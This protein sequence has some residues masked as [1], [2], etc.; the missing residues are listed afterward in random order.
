MK[1]VPFW[2]P[3]L[4][5]AVCISLYRGN[6]CGY[7]RFNVRGKTAGIMLRILGA[8]SQNLVAL[9]TRR[10][11]FANPYFEVVRG[12]DSPPKMNTH[13]FSFPLLTRS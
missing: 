13:I 8:Y 10:P 3:Q 2:A 9:L 7:R 4:W 12:Y 1:R 5:N 6:V 11:E